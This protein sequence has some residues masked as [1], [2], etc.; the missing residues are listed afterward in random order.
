ME[1]IKVIIA[2]DNKDW[3]TLVYNYLQS[4]DKITIL[5][6]TSDGEEQI[7]MI[8]S[9]EPDIVITDLKRKKGISGI[10]VIKR[11]KALNLTEAKFL[12]TTAGCYYQEQMDNLRDMGITHF[13]IKPFGLEKI[14]EELQAIQDERVYSLITLKNNID[15]K[16]KSIFDII[17]AKLSKQ[18]KV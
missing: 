17:L 5:G 4:Y 2:D 9:L 1:E 8:K 18:K 6:V 10:E 12:I 7:E 13:L 3:C 16:R 14:I 15:K 11:C